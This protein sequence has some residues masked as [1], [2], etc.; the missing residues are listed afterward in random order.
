MTMLMNKEVFLQHTK[1][2]V[3]LK[4][5]LY[6]EM[7]EIKALKVYPSHTNFVTFSAGERSPALFEHLKNNEIAIRDVGAHRLLARCLRVSVGSREQNRFFIDQIK[8][9]LG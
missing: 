4:Q 9:F 7:K 6:E 5:D 3:A 1:D 2:A 8:A